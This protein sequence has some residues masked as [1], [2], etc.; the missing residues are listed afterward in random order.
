MVT[1][2]DGWKA[3][4]NWA[5]RHDVEVPE[6]PETM[7]PRKYELRHA[8]PK[9]RT[10]LANILRSVRDRGTDQAIM[11]GRIEALAEKFERNRK[12]AYEEERYNE[13]DIWNDAATDAKRLIRNE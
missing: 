1:E 6:E 12:R 7:D 5:R 8:L 9:Q 3:G 13:C 2:E 11:E 10:L 4:V